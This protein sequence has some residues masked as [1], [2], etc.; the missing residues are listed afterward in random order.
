MLLDGISILDF[1][2]ARSEGDKFYI[3]KIPTLLSTLIEHEIS[4]SHQ[5]LELKRNYK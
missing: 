2:P 3:H 5:S 4:H 1:F